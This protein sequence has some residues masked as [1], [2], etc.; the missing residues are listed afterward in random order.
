MPVLP[1]RP[2]AVPLEQGRHEERHV[3]PRGPHQEEREGEVR[4]KEQG[5]QRGRRSRKPSERKAEV[6]GSLQAPAA[7]AAPGGARAAGGRR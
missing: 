4:R 2:L 1:R 7:P 5:N 6:A 3:H